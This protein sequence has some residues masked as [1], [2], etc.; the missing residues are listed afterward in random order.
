MRGV[1]ATERNGY[2]TGSGAEAR[3][4]RLGGTLAIQPH[5][6]GGIGVHAHLPLGRR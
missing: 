2:D 5:P 3:A 6:A 4:Q 1:K